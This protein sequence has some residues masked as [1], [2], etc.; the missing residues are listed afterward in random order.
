MKNTKRFRNLVILWWTV[1]FSLLIFIE[2][3]PKFTV[4]VVN[5]FKDLFPSDLLIEDSWY[6]VY[7][8]KEF[9]GYSNFNMKVLDIKE[10]RGFRLENRLFLNLPILGNLRSMMVTTKALLLSDYSLKDF[11]LDFKSEKYFLKISLKKR[12]SQKYKFVLK[13]PN[14]E[15]KKFITLSKRNFVYS[16]LT[17]IL[18]NYLPKGKRLVLKFL[19]IFT[20]TPLEVYLKNKG[21][22]FIKIDSQKILAYKIEGDFKGIKF[23][24][25]VDKNGRLLKEEFLNFTFLKEKPNKIFEKLRKKPSKDLALA[26]SVKVKKD[27]KDPRKVRYLK[28]KII[29]PPDFPLEDLS[30]HRQVYKIEG[31][32]ILLEIRKEKIKKILSYPFE[33]DFKEFL[34]QDL[35][36]KKDQKVKEAALK[37]IGKEKDSF[38]ILE[39]L[40]NWTYKNIKKVPTVSFPN[41]LDV[42]KFRKGDCNEHAVLLCGFLRSL[43]IP[44]FVNLGLVYQDKRFWYHAWVSS[45]IGE[46]VESDP[47]FGQTIADATHIRL[48][49]GDITRQTEIL[50]L[51]GKIK[52]EILDYD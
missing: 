30:S 19:D 1:S 15:K 40:C 17:P 28:V 43:G 14:Y 8:K 7:F 48:L 5:S 42:L 25:W 11:S 37:I 49:K 6:G 24:A 18:L 9:V 36:I 23:Y 38:K 46:W 32:Q 50:K 34:V 35:F 31:D 21:K 41:T 10:G 16:P 39:K 51:L 12:G 13:T 52:I 3:L 33:S 20:Q 45:F 2:I 26:F 4:S 22:C 47:V 29:L 27:I 44:S